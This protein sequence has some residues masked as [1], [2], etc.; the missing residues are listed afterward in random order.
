MYIRLIRN[1][2]QGNAI[3][4][5]L[6]VDGRW[7]C[8][9]LERVGVLES[10]GLSRK[11]Q[12]AATPLADGTVEIAM[13]Y[14]DKSQYRPEGYDHISSYYDGAGI[15]RGELP[16]GGVKRFILQ[17]FD[18]PVKGV[19]VTPDDHMLALSAAASDLLQPVHQGLGIT[20]LEHQV[21]HPQRCRRRGHIV[22]HKAGGGH[23]RWPA[24]PAGDAF[25]QAQAVLFR[26]HQVQHQDLG[27]ALL[28]DPARLFPIR[29]GA[30]NCEPFRPLQC[31]RQRR[32]EFF[33]VVGDQYACSFVHELPLLGYICPGYMRPVSLATKQS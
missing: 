20:G 7:F 25:E 28:Q 4:G 27:P 30:R 29:G 21:R 2:P 26:E 3:T 32:A 10:E 18:T 6:V 11:S 14:M 12:V 22:R 1:K 15:Y 13:A 31:R 33:G 24:V 17:S 16:Y 19:R 23:H 9:T 5:R 8:N